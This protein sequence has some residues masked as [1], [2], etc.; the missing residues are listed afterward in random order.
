MS[1]SFHSVEI[2]IVVFYKICFSIIFE[3]LLKAISNYQDGIWQQQR[4]LVIYSKTKNG[5]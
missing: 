4:L 2:Y 3:I 1:Y 5:R